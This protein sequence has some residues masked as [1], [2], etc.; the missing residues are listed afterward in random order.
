[1]SE[2]EQ[3][4]GLEAALLARAQKLADEYLANGRQ[5]HQQIIED[6]NQ[7]LRIE[8]EREV[9]AAKAHAE[10]VYQQHVQAAELGLRAE[11]DRTRWSLVNAVLAELP[12]RLAEFAADEMH[13]PPLLF[14]WL[15]EGV[16]AI[17]RDELE[18]SFNARDLE[19]LHRDWQG[20]AQDIAPDKQLHLSKQPLDST[21]GVLVGSMDG[22]IRFDN[23]F[24]GRMERMAEA[25]QHVIAE[26]LIPGEVHNG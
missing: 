6:A 11:L 16:Q 12:A 18:V 9:L 22:N 17:E 15:R 7:R 3:I 20:H 13:Y 1:M 21:G 14:A 5:I 23:T 2:S 25:L 24:E 8:E 10:R 4:S 19:R 26:R